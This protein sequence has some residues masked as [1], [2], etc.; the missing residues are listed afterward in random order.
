LTSEKESK[1]QRILECYKKMI[2]VLSRAYNVPPPR[3]RVMSPE[4]AEKLWWL[5]AYYKDGTITIAYDT[6]PDELIHEFIHYL[7]DLKGKDPTSKEAEEEAFRIGQEY[8]R[9]IFDRCGEPA[10]KLRDDIWRGKCPVC[11]VEA[12]K[13]K[14]IEDDEYKF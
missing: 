2:E 11:L 14:L 10:W 5:G 8:G 4:E 13:V 12:C 1:A 3:I 9:L 6:R 7:Q